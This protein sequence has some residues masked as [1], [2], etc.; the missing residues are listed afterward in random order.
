MAYWSKKKSVYTVQQLTQLKYRPNE[1][2]NIPIS[3]IEME[4]DRLG[5]EYDKKNCNQDDI[6]KILKEWI[7]ASE[8]IDDH[9]STD[10]DTMISRNV[11]ETF[12]N[13]KN[14]SLKHVLQSE[15]TSN[16]DDFEST[17]VKYSTAYPITFVYTWTPY[18]TKAVSFIFDQITGMF[19]I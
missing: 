19:G 16:N 4:C 15:K 18:R 12:A 11:Y 2:V 9:G 13:D 6:V 1:T 10:I 5:I 3:D 8:N 7:M 14:P 17:I